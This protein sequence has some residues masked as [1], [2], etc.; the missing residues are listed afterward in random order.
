MQNIHFLESSRRIGNSSVVVHDQGGAIFVAVVIILIDQ[1]G[2]MGDGVQVFPVMKKDEIV[3]NLSAFALNFFLPRR[4]GFDRRGRPRTNVFFVTVSKFYSGHLVPDDDARALSRMTCRCHEAR[5]DGK[6][7][8]R[9]IHTSDLHLVVARP[10]PTTRD[11]SSPDSCFCCCC[12]E[13]VP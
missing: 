4:V 13:I 3:A 11:D 9:R 5:S 8:T 6:R 1:G 10:W 2:W 7:R 12:Y